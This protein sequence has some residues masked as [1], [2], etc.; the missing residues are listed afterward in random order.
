MTRL[1]PAIW[2]GGHCRNWQWSGKKG[3]RDEYYKCSTQQ[4]EKSWRLQ[5]QPL[6]LPLELEKVAVSLVAKLENEDGEG[7]MVKLIGRK[8][9]W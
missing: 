1:K 9:A 5:L 3:C 4:R 7:E 2:G 8:G 6:K